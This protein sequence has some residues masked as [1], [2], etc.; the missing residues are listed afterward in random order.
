MSDAELREVKRVLDEQREARNISSSH[1]PVASPVLFATKQNGTLRFCIHYHRLNTVTAKDHYP[2]PRIDE[3]LRLVLGSK[4]L[5]KINIHLAFHG[6]E[7]EE[8]SRPLTAF[9]TTFGAWQW[10]IMPFGLSN[11]PWTWQR[12]IN[13]TLFPGLGSFCCA[14]V[15][16]IIIWSPSAEQHRRDVQTVLRRL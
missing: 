6:V 13:D 12:V 4:I 3:V 7:I 14:Y 15:D 9:L 11:A 16:N 8:K 5:S 10:N 1:A 2:L